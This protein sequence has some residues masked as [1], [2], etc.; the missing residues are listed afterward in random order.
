MNWSTGSAIKRVWRENR[1]PQREESWKREGTKE[2]KKD[3][4]GWKLAQACEVLWWISCCESGGQTVVKLGTF[5]AELIMWGITDCS[6][7]VLSQWAMIVGRSRWRTRTWNFFCRTWSVKKLAAICRNISVDPRPSRGLYLPR[8]GVLDRSMTVALWT[9]RHV[10]VVCCVYVTDIEL[11]KIEKQQCA[12]N[13]TTKYFWKPWQLYY[14]VFLR[15]RYN[16]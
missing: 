12:T 1:L 7:L 16:S 5:D 14:R 13:E 10:V 8:A 4:R 2:G 15:L 11:C 3:E 9:A 6:E